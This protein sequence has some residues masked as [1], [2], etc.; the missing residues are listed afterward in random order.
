MSRLTTTTSLTRPSDP[1]TGTLLYETDTNRLL[2]WDGAS[3]RV[4]NADSLSNPSGGTDDIHYPSGLFTNSSANYYITTT[5]QFH[6]D[7]S[8]ISG[9]SG[10]AGFTHG[11][12]VWS[13][14]DRTNNRYKL[15]SYRGQTLAG[16]Y[17]TIDLNESATMG[18]N[19]CTAP[20]I[21]NNYW[22]GYVLDS[23]MVTALSPEH[24]IFVIQ[25]SDDKCAAFDNYS[26][27][28]QSSTG[29]TLNQMRTF[30]THTPSKIISTLTTGPWLRIARQTDT[31]LDV[32]D[33]ESGG[34]PWTHV[35][36]P[37]TAGAALDISN[38]VMPHAKTGY[39]MKMWELIVFNS[40]LSISEMN[41]V[42]DYLQNKYAGISDSM[43]A[44]GTPA[45][46]T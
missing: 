16:S 15:D 21:N 5:P 46:T 31:S 18:D 25:A 19:S 1:V 11:D 41:T 3:Y 34:S 20:C 12:V 10:T 23:R 2:Y 39:V 26:Y 44:G 30:T 6:L 40:A 28:G 29:I 33:S 17:A 22:D 27:H 9:V 37:N 24:T 4:F 42:K 36:G 35:S 43:P 32:W 7:T 45:L 38:G 8:Y 14:Y 13:W